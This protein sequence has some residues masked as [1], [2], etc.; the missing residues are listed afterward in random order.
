MY[1]ISGVEGPDIP[2]HLQLLGLEFEVVESSDI[3]FVPLVNHYG[4]QPPDFIQQQEKFSKNCHTVILY[5]LV[6][7]GDHELDVYRAQ[8]NKFD[9]PNKI[10]LTVN[11]SADIPVNCP[12]IRWDFMWNRF[13]AYYHEQN[14]VEGLHHYTPGAY[15]IPEISLTPFRSKEFISLYRR[16]DVMRDALYDIVSRYNGYVSNGPLGITLEN[17]PVPGFKPIDNSFYNDSY[18]SIYVESN[19]DRKNLIH[20]TEKTYDPLIKGHMILPVTN[21]G[22]IAYLRTKGFEFPDEIDYSFDT[23]L[24]QQHRLDA[25]IKEFK[26]LLDSA[27]SVYMANADKIKH[28]QH[29]F[30]EKKYDKS[31][32][33]IFE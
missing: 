3:H 10:Y 22:A 19:Y 16:K 6:N 8:V 25:I 23:I 13:I 4:T 24:N 7:L 17:S 30:S 28:N 14:F 31:I 20:L 26:L 29:V 5:D 15:I 33:Q 1:K 9:H 21:P 27:R 18:F 12:V 32:L 2:F 11:Q